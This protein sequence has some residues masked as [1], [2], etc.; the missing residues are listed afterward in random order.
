M[1]KTAWI[2]PGTFYFSAIHGGLHASG[3]AIEGAGV[4]YS[5]L[6]RVTPA[7]NSQ[8]VNNMIT[9]TSS[10][11]RNVA[12][13]CNASNR[14]GNNNNGAINFSGNGWL[15]DNVW[16]QHATS[17][18]WCSGVG[19]TAQNCRVLSVWS[20]GGNFNNVEGT[21]GIGMNL[22][23]S[24]NFVRG[25]GDD[26]MAINSVNYNVNGSTKTYYTM[27]SNIT[28]INNTAIGAWGGKN[29]ALYGGINDLVTNNL[30]RD[31]ARYIGLG[32]GKFGVNGSDLVSARVIGNVVLRCGGNGYS[33]QQQAMMIGNGG[34]GQS[35]GTVANA[36]CASNVIM[37]SLYG[38][39]GFS[40]S[41]NIV[42]QYNTIID[43]GQDGIVVGGGSLGIGVMGNALINSNTVTG[44]PAGRVAFTNNVTGYAAVFPISAA[45]YNSMSGVVTE[46]CD[47]GGQNLGGI[48]AGD[49]SAYNNINLTGVNTF[50]ARVASAGAGGSIEIHLDSPTGPLIG[51]VAVA[52]T[53]GWHTYANVYG[54][55]NSASGA[56]TVYLVYTGGAGNLFNLEFFGFYSAS[57]MLSHQLVVGDTYALKAVVNGKYVTAANGGAGS[58]IAQSDSIG[59]AEQFQIVDAGGGNIGLLALINDQYVC[60]ENNG[61]SPL[62]ASPAAR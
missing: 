8:G 49:W 35:V 62:I 12:L 18:F 44:L 1:G 9:T 52:G 28:Y 58:L 34:D 39:V 38:A 11:L 51:T 32:V 24:N 19:G 42:F 33:Q 4:W 5:T 20:D 16:I 47:E 45:S 21:A 27:M 29:M 37:G 17:A 57:P 3:I 53:G 46:A 36:Y 61:T 43:P 54:R 6:Y 7:G 15:V 59:A 48:E 23:Y 13:D 41:T 50:I 25:T 22:T 26:A 56:H 40:T 2:P 14:A 60:S 10:T 31:T 55:I 30:L